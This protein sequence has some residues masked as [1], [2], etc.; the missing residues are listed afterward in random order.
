MSHLHPQDEAPLGYPEAAGDKGLKSG[1]LGLMS[2]IVSGYKFVTP[3]E[4][5]E[6]RDGGEDL[7]E[8]VE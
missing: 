8:R 5:V 4:I 2:S 3:E 7:L 6:S 1:A